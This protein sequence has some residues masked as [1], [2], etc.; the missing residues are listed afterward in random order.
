MNKTVSIVIPCRNE[1]NY[2]GQCIESFIK[3]NYPQQLVNIIIADGMST[4]NTRKIIKEYMRKYSNILLID[5]EDLVAPIG[6]NKGIAYS[7]SDIIIIFGAHALADKNFIKENVVALTNND[8]GCVGGPI[9][10]ISE[11]DIGKAI[12]NAMSCPFGVGNA[13]FRFSQ[14]ETYVDTV[15]FGAY[16]KKTLDEIGGFDE[17]LVRN[18]DDELNF[19]VI[20]SGKKI[21]LSPKIKSIYYSRG[22]FRKLYKQ[23]FQYGFW[24]V[25]VMQKH[26]RLASIRHLIPLLFVIYLLLSIVLGLFFSNIRIISLFIISIYI[27]LDII[28]TY[29]VSKTNSLRIKLYTIIIFPILHISYGLGF[30]IGIINFYIKSSYSLERENK[31]MSR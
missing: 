2:I 10:T 24:K 11:N 18:Q 30:A 19:R 7:K 25:R 20:E 3:Q 4:D 6:M 16:N 13:L 21:L 27:L 8:I 5:N 14:K 29:K 15:A 17:E 23:Y 28:F 26:K 12:A 9:T 31:I 1:E 22:S